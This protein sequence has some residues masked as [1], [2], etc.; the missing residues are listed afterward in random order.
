MQTFQNFP[1]ETWMRIVK[2][3]ATPSN[4]LAS[5]YGSNMQPEPLASERDAFLTSALQ[6]SHTCR[7]LKTICGSKNTSFWRTALR[8]WFDFNP[9]GSTFNTEFDGGEGPRY[10]SDSWFGEYLFWSEHDDDEVTDTRDIKSRKRRDEKIEKLGKG[11]REGFEYYRNAIR[12]H[13]DEERVLREDLVAWRNGV[14]VRR[15]QFAFL[16]DDNQTWPD[17]EDP[18]TLFM[19]LCVAH[20]LADLC[21]QIKHYTT[22]YPNW[23]R[24]P[25][26]H[27]SSVQT[28]LFPSL[29]ADASP[30]AYTPPPWIMLDHIGYAPKFWM[31]SKPRKFNLTE[32]KL[33]FQDRR[34]GEEIDGWGTEHCFPDDKDTGVDTTKIVKELFRKHVVDCHKY[35]AEIHGSAMPDM[36]FGRMRSGRWLGFAYEHW[37]KEEARV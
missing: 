4:S 9:G 34:E 21:T 23:S 3:L 18:F 32:E 5:D 33:P 19:D 37:N 14:T 24:D 31:C 11:K 1:P 16:V 7:L 35:S 26:A 28:V 17:F 20:R 6:L 36:I 27:K 13:P 2:S 15:S 25:S 22:W 30:A 29:P 10:Y 8:A 12:S